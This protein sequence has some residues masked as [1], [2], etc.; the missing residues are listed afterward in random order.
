MTQDEPFEAVGAEPPFG[1]LAR[2]H[3]AFDAGAEHVQEL[4]GRAGAGE[5]R[6]PR[7]VIGLGKVAAGALADGP[8]VRALHGNLDR[9]QSRKLD[10]VHPLARTILQPL[11]F[12]L[13]GAIAHRAVVRP[14][15]CRHRHHRRHSHG[16]IRAHNFGPRLTRW[17]N[18]RTGGWRNRRLS[19]KRA[20]VERSAPMRWIKASIRSFS[21]SVSRKFKYSDRLSMVVYPSNLAPGAHDRCGWR[22]QPFATAQPPITREWPALRARYDDY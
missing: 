11:V 3:V 13:G 19:A 2:N 1:H 10:K 8:Q 15:A 6:R 20:R 9:A 5:I 17:R 7:Q 14:H 21:F 16:T 12:P 4:P 22:I 18:R